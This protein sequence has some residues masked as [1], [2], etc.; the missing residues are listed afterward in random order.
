VGRRDG[1]EDG[2]GV[3]DEGREERRSRWDVEGQS[4]YAHLLSR[5]RR[6]RRKSR[7]RARSRRRRLRLDSRSGKSPR[8]DEREE[9]V[10]RE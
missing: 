6:N 8:L 7:C 9:K 10:E 5:N 1:D 3:G 4:E 2:D